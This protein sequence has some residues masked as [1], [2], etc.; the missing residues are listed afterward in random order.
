[1]A[2]SNIMCQI[3]YHTDYKKYDLGDGH[4]FNPVRAEMVLDFL[5]E[6]DI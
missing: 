4:P 1:M 2:C 5:K 6:K 3:I